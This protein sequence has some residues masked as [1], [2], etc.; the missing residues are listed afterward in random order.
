MRIDLRGSWR[1]LL[2]IAATYVAFLLFA[3]FGFLAQLQHDLADAGRVRA[4]MAAMGIAGL[5]ASLGTAWLLGRIAGPRLV[6]IGLGAVAIVAVGSL[7]C[8]GF[9]SLIVAAVAIGAS[10]GLLTVAVAASLPEIVPPGSAG[11]AVGIATGAAYFL[12]NVPVLF[13]ASSVVRALVPAGLAGVAVAFLRSPQCRDAPWGVSLWGVSGAGTVL[14]SKTSFPGASSLRSEVL[15]A[16]RPCP[17]RRR[18][19]GRLY[20][21]WIRRCHG[22]LSRPGV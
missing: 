16:D 9:A 15:Q 10:I 13:E 18:P 17:S 1:G 7:A 6:R 8:H 11:M 19:T 14:P 21:G 22:P 12:S 2:A 5:A 20:I 4:A 3:Q